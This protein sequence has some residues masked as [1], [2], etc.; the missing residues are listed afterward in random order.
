MKKEVTRLIM[1][2]QNKIDEL[3][4]LA[5]VQSEYIKALRSLLADWQE[6]INKIMEDL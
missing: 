4:E 2:T 6:S 5:Q 3:L 1:T